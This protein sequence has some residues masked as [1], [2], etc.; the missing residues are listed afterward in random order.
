MELE[1][2]HRRKLYDDRDVE[3]EGDDFLR[4]D[5]KW[6]FN[7]SLV[8]YFARGIDLELSYAYELNDSLDPEK[9]WK[10]HLGRFTLSYE[11]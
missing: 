6:H 1:A 3:I 4:R 10:A 2:K 8:K 5:F 11:L 7:A 9:E